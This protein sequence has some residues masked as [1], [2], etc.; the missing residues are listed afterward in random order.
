MVLQKK[1]PLLLVVGAALLFLG[2]GALALWV[3]ARRGNLIKALPT[4]A[5]AI[6]DEAV[7]VLAL[8]TDEAQWRRLRQFGT[9]T[10]QAQLDQV[11]AQWR[12]LLVTRAGINPG[13]DLQPWVGSE[14]TLALLPAADAIAPAVP[15]LPPALA[16]ESN[17]VVAIPI[18]NASAAQEG[19][20][21]RLVEAKEIG[22]NPYRGITLQQLE[23]DD[24]TPLYAAVLN[25]ELALVSPQVACSSNPSMP[26][27]M[28]NRW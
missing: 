11:L 15:G 14:I 19:L 23:G 2:G 20:G 3:M 4:G 24:E 6:P 5:N 21:N 22:D 1:P 7:L 9:P 16:L 13:T 25:P 8:S 28:A 27:E 10:T 12:D 18:D 17:V 26:F